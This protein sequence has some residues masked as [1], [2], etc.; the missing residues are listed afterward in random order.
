MGFGFVRWRFDES[1]HVAT[2]F[3]EL[4]DLFPSLTVRRV[5]VDASGVI[6]PER[7]NNIFAVGDNSDISY[8]VSQGL[9]ERIR[10]IMLR[11][12]ISK[13]DGT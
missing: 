1:D 7:V 3:K 11:V 4:P 9:E 5:R 8:S 2:V 10:L 6:S 13:R 12:N